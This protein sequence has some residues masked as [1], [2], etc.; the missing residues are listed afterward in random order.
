MS[1]AAQIVAVGPQSEMQGLRSIG[2]ELFPADDASDVEDILRTQANREEVRLILLSETVAEDME[3]VMGELRGR[4]GTVIML[5]PSHRGSSGLTID[6]MRRT[7]E[8]S[9]GVDVISE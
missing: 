9:L 8:R 3:D 7:M 6:W 2:V 4:K 1:D 5:L